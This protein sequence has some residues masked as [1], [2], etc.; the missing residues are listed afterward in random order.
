MPNNDICVNLNVSSIHLS[1][2]FIHV[3]FLR[4]QS[5][6]DERK[7]SGGGDMFF[8]RT[9]EDLSA[10]EGEIILAEYSE[11]FPPLL[12]QVGM[13]TKM[14]NFYKRVSSNNSVDIILIFYFSV[15]IHR[16]EGA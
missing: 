5:R 7:A 2:S 13:A 12:M 1:L 15:P 8:M 6:E 16:E 9:P 11:E 3:L 4:P 14:K 10:R